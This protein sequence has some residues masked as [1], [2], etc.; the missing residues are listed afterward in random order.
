MRDLC[1][2]VMLRGTDVNLVSGSRKFRL[3]Y[4]GGGLLAI[5][6]AIICTTHECDLPCRGIL[7]I[8]SHKTYLI[9]YALQCLLAE[10]RKYSEPP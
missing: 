10:I 8:T 2:M 3:S 5:F 9:G 4:S 6:H 7:R 1:Q